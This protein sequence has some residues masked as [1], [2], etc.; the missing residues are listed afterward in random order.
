[1]RMKIYFIAFLVACNIAS[2]QSEKKEKMELLNFMVGEWIGT[3]K[4]YEKG[5]VTKEVPA[6][7]KISFDLDKHILVIELNSE[8]LQLHTIIY[9]D[10]KDKTYYYNPFSKSGAR[11]L[12]AVYE[13]GKLVVNSNNTK[14]F[15]FSPTKNG[16]FVEY[17]EQLIDGKWI[18]Y[19]EDSFQ[20]SQ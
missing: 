20:D 4:I 12:P 1:M 6:Y 13:D 19:F 7:E 16:G 8:L 3:S 11:K 10:E 17:G 2:G 9:Y 5:S 15:I 18:K 14:R